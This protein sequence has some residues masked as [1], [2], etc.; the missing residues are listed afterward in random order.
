MTVDEHRRLG[1]LAVLTEDDRDYDKARIYARATIPQYWLVDVGRGRIEVFE[2]PDHERNPGGYRERGSL[3][4]TDVLEVIL[5][6]RKVGAIPVS[7]LF[8]G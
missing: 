3:Q 5:N 1:E 6:G 7:K 8:P 4:A 2:K